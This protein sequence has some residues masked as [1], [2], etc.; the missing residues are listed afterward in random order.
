[1]R[2]D[3]L[4][5]SIEALRQQNAIHAILYVAVIAANMDFPEFVLHNSRFLQKH[6]LKGRAFALAH[7]LDLVGVD[8]IGDSAQAGCDFLASRIE[9]GRDG[10]DS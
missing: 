5:K 3:F 7:C 10:V 1:V 9:I 8:R 6:L 2:I 4:R